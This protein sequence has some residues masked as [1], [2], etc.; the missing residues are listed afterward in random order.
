MMKQ[1]NFRIEETDLERLEAIAK[2]LRHERGENITIS[3][4]VRDAIS[5]YI[6]REDNPEQK[7][8]L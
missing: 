6:T 7:R 5:Q 3:D 8:R 2:K 1:F 4:L